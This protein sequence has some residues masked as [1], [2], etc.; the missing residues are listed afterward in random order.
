MELSLKGQAGW[1]GI[2]DSTTMLPGPGTFRTLDG[3]VV[4]R[5]GSELRQ[6]PG[7][8]IIAN[9]F[10]GEPFTL[11]AVTAGN[12]T[13]VELAAPFDN[14]ANLAPAGR[15]Y[16]RGHNVIPDDTYVY[17]RTGPETFTIPFDSIATSPDATGDVWV[18]RVVHVHQLAQIDGRIMVVGETAQYWTAAPTERRNIATWVGTGRPDVDA[19]EDPG[20]QQAVDTGIIYW[21]NPT[22]RKFSSR[23]W[24]G[25]GWNYDIPSR[26]QVEPIDSRLVIAVPGLGLCLQANLGAAPPRFP[27][28]FPQTNSYPNHRRTKMLGIPKGL[29]KTDGDPQF[30]SG[31]LTNTNT[32]FVAVGY[33]DA[34]TGEVG[35]PST[36]VKVDL[37][38][39]N[40]GFTIAYI[41]P[42]G[43]MYEAS[44]LGAILYTSE[45]ND[46]KNTLLFPSQIVGPWDP[47]DDYGVVDGSLASPFWR[48]FTVT[49]EPNRNQILFPNRA[50]VLEVPMRGGNWVRHARGR[51]FVGGAVS[52]NK[53]LIG[54]PEQLGTPG[55]DPLSWFFRV[56][57]EM[58][59]P[60][61][62]LIEESL[63][64]YSH[65][66]SA[67]AGSRAVD[68]AGAGFNLASGGI[69]RKVSELRDSP[70]NK[71]FRQNFQVTQPLA[72]VGSPS[73]SNSRAMLVRTPRSLIHYGEEG[74]PASSPLIN[75]LEIDRVLGEEST[76]AARVGDSLL[77]FTERSTQLYT[78][79]TMPRKA[80]SQTLSTVYGCISASSVVDGPFGAAWLSAEGPC[81]WAGREVQ[82]I[83]RD[84]RELWETFRKDSRGR[85]E[86][87]TGTVDL[88][89]KLV[90]WPMRVAAVGGD[91]T[92]M[93]KA[94]SDV[95]LFWNYD[96]GAFSTQT[97]AHNMAA[98]ASLHTA[99]GTWAPSAVADVGGRLENDM[100]PVFGWQESS[101]DRAAAVFES[102]IT[103]RRAP[104]SDLITMADPTGTV[105]IGENC[106]IVSRSG[107]T[108][109]WFGSAASVSA[110][111]VT[112]DDGDGADWDEGDRFVAYILPMDIETQGIQLG[113]LGFTHTITGVVIR[114]EVEAERA[115]ALVEVTNEFG[116][117][118]QLSNG[119]FGDR[120]MTGATRFPFGYSA[121]QDSRLRIRIWA[122]GPVSVKDIRFVAA[123]KE[124]DL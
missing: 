83:G 77:G 96:T 44:S 97:L 9:P 39:A 76:A 94:T 88:E 72:A 58:S 111:G 95:W 93:A 1:K 54:W 103:A 85:M 37:A 42:R 57:D 59:F 47:D 23:D 35:I 24:V 70:T 10:F 119:R 71:R 22:A 4:S 17:T 6:V 50:P 20:V 86:Y 109:R 121:A 13:I 69:S 63:S 120:L 14:D 12:P 32:Y 61:F 52:D 68:D 45:A 66:P 99:D 55:T 100:R 82:W 56:A 8:R 28:S 105:A 90:I 30:V 15:V 64:A 101:V 48:L 40:T 21:P 102:A 107:S 53:R 51:V 118:T 43:A 34:A 33:F 27:L 116:V 79:S 18:Q 124:E 5:D 91:D 104:N 7:S 29:L 11:T 113:E 89:R 106:M 46:L 2:V 84:I 108:I 92:D 74:F 122:D 62:D 117:V 31:S 38:G 112:V 25:F 78:W 65:F 75:F 80:S 110:S 114:A 49:N 16:I 19:P 41:A 60:T 26:M 87:A 123:E 67:Y 81:M 115:Y 98:A 36:S 3:V 73:D